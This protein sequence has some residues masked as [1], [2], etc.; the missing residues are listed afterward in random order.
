M[1]KVQLSLCIFILQAI[2]ILCSPPNDTLVENVTNSGNQTD[3]SLTGGEIGNRL[4][5]VPLT[6]AIND[7]GVQL[8]RRLN[9]ESAAGQ[10]KNV[11]FSPLSIGQIFSMLISSSQN[12]TLTEL[13]NAFGFADQL[14]TP[15]N[16]NGAFK[17]L[18]D[19][20]D[21]ARLEASGRSLKLSLP[22]IALYSIDFNIK[23]SFRR[24]LKENYKADASKVDFS[25][26][27][28]VN[29]INSFVNNNTNGLI[30]KLVE[31]L[32][33]QTKL[34]LVNAFYFKGDWIKQFERNLVKD[35]A[36]HNADQTTAQVKTMFKRDS[37]DYFE[38]NDVQVI[39]LPYQGK[40]YLKFSFC[41][42]VCLKD[43]FY[44]RILFYNF[45]ISIGNASMTILLPQKNKSVD[46]LIKNLN[47]SL[48][49]YY[50]YQMREHQ[51][52][53]YLP[54]LKIEASIDLKEPMADLGVRKIFGSDAN[55]SGVSSFNVYVS[56]AI[57][58][59][60]LDIN[61]QG[62]LIRFRFAV[63]LFLN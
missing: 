1:C 37:Y 17:L 2:S 50:R 54:K 23:K 6:D 16:V 49:D 48:I 62:K 9:S 22:S 32:D 19:D 34:A 43:G 47:N 28:G 55:L 15:E 7:F 40:F 46:D 11:A 8:I 30:P 4:R 26:A 5:L 18:L 25:N 29:V 44:S 51:V 61:E 53:L 36:F 39:S 42:V 20:Y 35:R 52:E 14:Q 41:S 38:D 60:F 58:K 57:H 33:P 21:K 3:D 24:N 10:A 13:M 63:C 12:E 56:D 45:S 31:K 27:D 59:A